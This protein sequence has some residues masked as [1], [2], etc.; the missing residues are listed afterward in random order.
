MACVFY[1]RRL[2]E[3]PVAGRRCPCVGFPAGSSRDFPLLHWSVESTASMIP[4]DRTTRNKMCQIREMRHV[5]EGDENGDSG[6]SGVIFACHRRHYP[7]LRERCCTMT[8]QEGQHLL[9]A[10]ETK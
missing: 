4:P 3:A 8:T 1:A 2:A 6:V 5:H 7:W 9:F 10:L